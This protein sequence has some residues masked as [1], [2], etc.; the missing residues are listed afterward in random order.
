LVM[1]NASGDHQALMMIGD[2]ICPAFEAVS[3][4]KIRATGHH[5]QLPPV[6]L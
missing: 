2:D 5:Q 1:N 3:R 4:S 6:P